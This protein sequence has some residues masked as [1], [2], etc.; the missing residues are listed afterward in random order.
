MTHLGAFPWKRC[1]QGLKTSSAAAINPINN[2]LMDALHNWA[3]MHCDDKLA[4]A[5]QELESF[6]GAKD[7]LIQRFDWVLTKFHEFGLTLG[8][9][10]VWILLTEAQYVSHVISKGTVRPSPSMVRTIVNIPSRLSNL[11]E[12]QFLCA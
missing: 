6:K 7:G 8:W 4:W 12:V 9:F 10:K 11:K 5:K 1:P 3:L 2:L